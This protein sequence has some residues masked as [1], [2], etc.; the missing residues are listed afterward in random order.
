MSGSQVAADTCQNCGA[1]V[2]AEARFCPSCG[3]PADA[4]STVPAQV[5]LDET[6]P[7]PVAVQRSEPHWFGVAPPQLLLASAVVA[8]AL[9]FVLFALGHWPYGLIL[10][11]V[12]ALLLAA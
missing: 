2:P 12:G 8:L 7:V 9:A 1:A 4:G 10:L 11:G 5:P 6:G 3:A